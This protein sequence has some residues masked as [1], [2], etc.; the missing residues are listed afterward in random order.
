MLHLR[1]HGQGEVIRVLLVSLELGRP[2]FPYFLQVP[3]EREGEAFHI[4]QKEGR[5]SDPRVAGRTSRRRQGWK[6]HHVHGGSSLSGRE[7][8]EGD[9]HG[10]CS[11]FLEEEALTTKVEHSCT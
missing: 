6:H 1:V 8:D 2:N 3:R 4:K 9:R 5:L 7:E 11:N 10:G